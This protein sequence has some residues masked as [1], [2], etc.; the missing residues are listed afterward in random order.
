MSSEFDRENGTHVVGIMTE[1]LKGNQLEKRAAD[2]I[3]AAPCG[4]A[5]IRIRSSPAA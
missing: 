5:P 4:W 2:A 1:W 3:L